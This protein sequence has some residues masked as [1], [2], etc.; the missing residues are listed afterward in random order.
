M[1]ITES[2]IHSPLLGNERRVWLQVPP[3]D[4]STAAIC[5][6][7]DGEYYVERMDAPAV[8]DELQ[9]SPTVSPFAVA[10]VSHV[11]HATRSKESTCNNRF[12]RFVAE[13]LAPCVK[14]HCGPS[15]EN[16]PMILGGLS[17][18]GLAAAHAVLPTG[19]AASSANRLRFGGRIS[20]SSTSTKRTVPGRCVFGFRVV[21]RKRPNTSS[22]VQT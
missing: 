22:M 9:R 8:I 5:I 11:D 1:K 18:T 6:L 4:Q 12:A 7:L 16:L 19:L 15:A 3:D 17:L 21:H 10:Y 13:E 20:G 14:R 2:L